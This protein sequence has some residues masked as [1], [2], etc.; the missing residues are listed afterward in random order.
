MFA[1]MDNG[2][3]HIADCLIDAL[4]MSDGKDVGKTYNVQAGG[5]HFIVQADSVDQAQA[6]TIAVFRKH[7]KQIPSGFQIQFR[8]L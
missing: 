7:H 2:T 8:G 6:K 4:L 5:Y 1:A 3:I